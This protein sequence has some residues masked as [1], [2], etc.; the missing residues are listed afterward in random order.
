MNTKLARII[1]LSLQ[2]LI[3]VII[4]VTF[5]SALG[6]PDMS[7]MIRHSIPCLIQTLANFLFALV[8]FLNYKKTSIIDIQIASILLVSTSLENIRIYSYFSEYSFR[9]PVSNAVVAPIFFFALILSATMFC[10]LSILPQIRSFTT[11]NN[12]IFIGIL[13][14]LA[15]VVFGPRISDLEHLEE[16]NLYIIL[17]F[18]LYIAA[19]VSFFVEMISNLHTFNVLKQVSQLAVVVG[20][21]LLSTRSSIGL[22]YLGV[23][24]FLAGE[25]T[26]SIMLITRARRYDVNADITDDSIVTT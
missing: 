7:Q 11:V 24:L 9:E 23:G 8:L 12:M 2:S 13:A 3:T 22:S 25:L 4:G 18:I 5:F 10:V 15:I 17:A 16:I 26:L 14:A 1:M 20:D 21:F 19:I 6:L